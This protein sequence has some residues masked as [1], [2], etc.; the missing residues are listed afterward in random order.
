MS[1]NITN[2]SLHEGCNQSSPKA[3]PHPRPN[4]V[5]R[6]SFI[7]RFLKLKKNPIQVGLLTIKTMRKISLSE[8]VLKG[9]TNTVIRSERS[10]EL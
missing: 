6:R 7:M 10:V 9:L 5:L 8:K 1:K 2:L 3:I 4:E